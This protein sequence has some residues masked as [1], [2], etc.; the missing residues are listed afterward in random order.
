MEKS[1]KM[2]LFFEIY[3]G[4]ISDIVMSKRTLKNFRSLTP[5][6]KVILDRDFFSFES[7]FLLKDDAH[8]IAA[9]LV[10]KADKT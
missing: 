4:S 9:P 7:L 1:R 10:S 3:H 6:I 5:K 2:P 8:I